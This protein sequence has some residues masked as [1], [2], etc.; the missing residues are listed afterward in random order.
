MLPIDVDDMGNPRFYN[1]S[2][3]LQR[4]FLLCQGDDISAVKCAKILFI[5][6]NP[7]EIITSGSDDQ[8][9]SLTFS[10]KVIIS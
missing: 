10:I 4:K 3:K 7:T 5:S 9:S 6:S 2:I 1:T 8:K